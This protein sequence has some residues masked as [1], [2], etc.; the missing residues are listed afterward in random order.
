MRKLIEIDKLNKKIKNGN[1]EV[2]LIEDLSLEI[3][4]GEAVAAVCSPN[5]GLTYLLTC[6]SGMKH[7]YEGIIRYD[8]EIEKDL[9]YKVLYT[10]NKDVMFEWRT[11]FDNTLLF[12]KINSKQNDGDEELQKYVLDTFEK[13]KL[14]KYKDKYPSSLSGSIKNKISI[15]KHMMLKPTLLIMN[16]NFSNID[17]KTKT[18]LLQILRNRFLCDKNAILYATQNIDDVFLLADRILLLKPYPLSLVAS[19]DISDIG[20]ERTPELIKESPAYT[21]LSNLLS[22]E[23]LY[24]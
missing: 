16:D 17:Y 15:V 7:S 12:L 22:K 10:C 23:H 18:E 8:A 14:T 6:L 9:Y 24:D 1:K 11:V 13:Y 20:N 2:I 21:E 3:D 19:I 4:Y 5:P